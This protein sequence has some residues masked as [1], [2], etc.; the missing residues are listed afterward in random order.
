M[1]NRNSYNNSNYNNI[2]SNYYKQFFNLNN[3]EII[4]KFNSPTTID[5]NKN[6]PDL[7]KSFDLEKCFEE[8]EVE[9]LLC[10]ENQI[11]CNNCHKSSDAITKTE[12]YKSPNVLIIILN[13]GRGNIFECDIKFGLSLDINRFAK[14]ND[15]PKFYDLIGVISH[16]GESSMAGHFIAFC[17][18]FTDNWILFNDS[19]VKNV[20]EKDI[21]RG[22][23][24]ILF[25]QKRNLT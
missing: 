15:S 6:I 14:K 10:G 20:D 17:K 4:N 11:Y 18:H 21:F 3:N 23:P 25:Y 2:S 1:L 16:L 13:R 5:P 12:I 24:Y 8:F 22:T 19:I 7:P 9:D